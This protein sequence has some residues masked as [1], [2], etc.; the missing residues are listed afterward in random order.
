MWPE[1]PAESSSAL[2][3]HLRDQ[4]EEAAVPEE[5]RVTCASIR[6]TF[7]AVPAW[8]DSGKV[9]D[10]FRSVLNTCRRHEEG[11]RPGVSVMSGAPGLESTIVFS[12]SSADDHKQATAQ[13]MRAVALLTDQDRVRSSGFSR[14]FVLAK[15]RFVGGIGSS[16]AGECGNGHLP[17]PADLA[18]ILRYLFTLIHSQKSKL[19]P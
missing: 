1:D 2:S 17:C 16:V 15:L 7:F 6:E 18:V 14:F 3:P 13:A 8:T 19:L 9:F 4:N 12:P 5:W 10:Q 11:G